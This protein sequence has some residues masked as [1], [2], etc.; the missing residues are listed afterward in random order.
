MCRL[1]CGALDRVCCNHGVVR[2]RSPGGRACHPV[3]SVC[4]VHHLAFGQV[5]ADSPWNLVAPGWLD[6][7]MV[8][9]AAKRS[10]KRVRPR[11]T[12]RPRTA[13]PYSAGSAAG[14]VL[15]LQ[16]A[17][18]WSERNVPPAA[19]QPLAIQPVFPAPCIDA[20]RSLKKPT[21]LRWACPAAPLRRAR[22]LLCEVDRSGAVGR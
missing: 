13:N 15:R 3:A 19:S 4:D 14:A 8:P 20:F 12:R 2:Q 1:L 10:G 22:P 7:S 16:R 5:R 6:R 17:P 18:R 11:G 9:A 21:N